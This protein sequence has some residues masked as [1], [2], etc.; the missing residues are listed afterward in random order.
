MWIRQ[1]L[2][3]ADIVEAK[4]CLWD[5]Q[6]VMSHDGRQYQGLI[7]SCATTR[8]TGRG[9]GSKC[10]SDSTKAGNNELDKT[11]IEQGEK[12]KFGP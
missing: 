12:P 3:A 9:H 7:L 8:D 6:L 5:Y 10:M 4:D 11:K 2:L 1:P